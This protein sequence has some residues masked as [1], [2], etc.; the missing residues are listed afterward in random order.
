MSAY[1]NGPNK[2]SPKSAFWVNA[3]QKD[4]TGPIKNVKLYKCPC[5]EGIYKEKRYNSSIFSPLH[6]PKKTKA[7]PFLL[8]LSTRS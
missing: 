1:S 2:H 5:H 4:I 3:T 6:P 8:N 7:N